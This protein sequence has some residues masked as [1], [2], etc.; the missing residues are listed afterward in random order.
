MCFYRIPQN[1]VFEAFVDRMTEVV[2]A[3]AEV[4]VDKY[5]CSIAGTF[6]QKVELAHIVAAEVA[7]VAEA[8]TGSI[9]CIVGF[10]VVGSL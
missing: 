8:V 1:F 3:A 5:M 6:L 9:G 7:A 2:V 4:A 10:V